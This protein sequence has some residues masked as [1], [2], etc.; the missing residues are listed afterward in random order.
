MNTK[1]IGGSYDSLDLV[2][3]AE[4]VTD[5]SVSYT[6]PFCYDKYKKNGEPYKRAKKLI[7][8][9]GNNGVRK[10]GAR[11]NRIIHCYKGGL[12]EARKHKICGVDLVI[13]RETEGFVE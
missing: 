5:H 8:Y 10:L 2:V 6:C 13:T 1:P 11:F 9:H 7:H 4:K 12:E 3:N